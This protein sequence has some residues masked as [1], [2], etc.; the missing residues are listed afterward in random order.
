MKNKNLSSKFKG[1]TVS[2]ALPLLLVSSMILTNACGVKG[3][4]LAPLEP[5][6]IGTGEPAVPLKKEDKKNTLKR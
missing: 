4:P 1:S 5:P 3:K 6:P 2:A